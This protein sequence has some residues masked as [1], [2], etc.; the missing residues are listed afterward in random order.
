[1]TPESF[2]LIVGA[3]VSLFFSYI[4]GLNTWFDQLLP[5]YKRLIMAGVS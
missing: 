4:P 1:M 5:E 3:I 2:A